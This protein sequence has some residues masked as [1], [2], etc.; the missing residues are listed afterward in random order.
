MEAELWLFSERDVRDL[1]RLKKPLLLDSRFLSIPSCVGPEDGPL[2]EGS[3]K[4]IKKVQQTT[5]CDAALGWKHVAH[6]KL[7]F[8]TLLEKKSSRPSS[9]FPMVLFCSAS[10]AAEP[11]VVSRWKTAQRSSEMRRLLLKP[12]LQGSTTTLQ[13]YMLSAGLHSLLGFGSEFGLTLQH[14]VFH[15]RQLGHAGQVRVG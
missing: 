1:M 11:Q 8:M 14:H 2:T 10:K 4:K 7:S 6:L 15:R 9:S 13:L 3:L 12:W 5:K